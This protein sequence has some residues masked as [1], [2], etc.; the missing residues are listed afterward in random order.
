MLEPFDCLARAVER[1]L[2]GPAPVSPLDAHRW[3]NGRGD[4]AYPG[5]VLDRYADALVLQV[6]PTVPPAVVEAW[7]EASLRQLEPS[8]IVHKKVAREAGA[9][10]SQVVFGTLADGPTMVREAD[11][12][13]ECRLDD[14]LQTGLFL[15]HRDTRIYVR[16]WAPGVEVL[17]LFA[18]TGA[19]SVHAALAGALRVTNVDASKRA[20]RW[21][22][23]NMTASGLSPDDH[24]WFADDVL[25]HLRRGVD[26]QYGLVIVDPPVMGRA[27]KR[28]FS[29]DRDM[30]ALLSGAV[31][32][33]T[34]DGIV[35]FSTH[36]R[37]WTVEALRPV[38]RAAARANGREVEW[39]DEFGLPP[40]DH[41][42]ASDADALDRGDYLKTLVLR[43]P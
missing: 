41:P 36:A 6:R 20:L 32:K 28:T 18:Y 30:S 40:W 11:A 9:R 2:R 37:R 21:G 13:F 1:R 34:R 5:L 38:V 15:D 43:F 29:L 39:V 24:R 7:V 17:N 25:A 19:F 35:V 12:R 10:T 16:Q 33:V 26:G 8:V 14:G 4:G 42:T 22:R 27:A 23:S 3:V 31:R